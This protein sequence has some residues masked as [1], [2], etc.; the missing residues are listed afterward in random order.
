MSLSS[1]MREMY[2]QAH[3]LD[4]QRAKTAS[5]SLSAIAPVEFEV[6]LSGMGRQ[7]YESQNRLHSTSPVPACRLCW[8]RDCLVFRDRMAIT[9]DSFPFFPYHM[10]L[11]PVKPERILLGAFKSIAPGI[12]RGRVTAEHLDCRDWFT[13]ED[14]ATFA[15]VVQEAPDYMITQS[16]RGSGASV[17]EHIH[18][19]AFLK[20][21]TRLPLLEKSCFHTADNA[22][23]IWIN[24]HVSYGLLSRA[25]ASIWSQLFVSLS[26]QFGLPSNHYIKAD[27][28][29]GGVIAHYVPRTRELPQVTR[30]AE[31]DW[32]FGAFEVVGLYDAKM[33]FLY[34]TVT[35]D[36]ACEA[37]RSVTLQGRNIRTEM[38]RACS[39]LCRSLIP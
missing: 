31:V 15:Q 35:A 4:G 9:P 3:P 37:T 33:G 39:Y 26:E 38:E 36:E 6:F 12:R 21:Q 25:D 19:H 8:A 18:G 23:G 20:K 30:F 34:D 24:D 17:P 5:R 27:E 16:M 11:R 7:E 32:K 1:L 13:A 22:A 2:E 14:L 28:E 29:F 10:L